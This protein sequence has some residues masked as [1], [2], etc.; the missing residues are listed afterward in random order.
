[1]TANQFEHLSAESPED[2]F[3]QVTIEESECTPVISTYEVVDESGKTFTM[4]AEDGTI[5]PDTN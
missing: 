5:A 3:A 4:G 1:M 2:R